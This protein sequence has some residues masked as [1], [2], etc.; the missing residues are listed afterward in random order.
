[1]FNRFAI[2]IG[3]GIASALLFAV[4]LQ[5]TMTAM[6]LAYVTPLPLMI[7]ALGWGFEAGLIALGVACGGV[8]AALGPGPAILFGLTVAL[9]A[10]CLAALA[11]AKSIPSLPVARQ[12]LDLGTSARASVGS[13]VILAAIFGALVGAGILATMIV[14]HGGYQH[15]VEAFG[16]EM[17]ATIREVLEATGNSTDDATVESVS[18]AII[19]YS[20]AAIA[21]STCLM[22][23]ANLYAAA[24]S[25]QMSQRLNRP[26]LDVPTSLN[27]PRAFGAIA[28]IPFVVFFVTPEPAS[29]FAMIFA[30]AFGVVFVLQGL[31]MLH[32]LSRRAPARPALMIGLY[33]ACFV[34]PRW[35]LPALTIL[36]LIESFASL[37]AR[38]AMRPFPP[39]PST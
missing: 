6:A 5:G 9:P 15:G 17:K 10:W 38:A 25:A 8:A 20:P 21:S 36:G 11:G 39:K 18:K 13:L 3:A 12:L 35:V 26:W 2:P 19:N 1:M 7:A 37:R 31:A 4:I 30:G 28:I 16:A 33:L 14:M 22:L 32:A 27:V 24:R 23:L 34:A 29:R